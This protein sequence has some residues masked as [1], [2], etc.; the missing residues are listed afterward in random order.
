MNNSTVKE[1]VGLSKSHYTASPRG[2][3]QA[4]RKTKL[5][6]IKQRTVLN[7]KQKDRVRYQRAFRS[8]LI[9]RS[10]HLGR[11]L[12][13]EEWLAL[14]RSVRKSC[15]PDRTDPV[16]KLLKQV[17]S[18]LDAV[19]RL[20]P[21]SSSALDSSLDMMRIQ[22]SVLRQQA[23]DFM[24]EK[25][26]LTETCPHFRH[27][28]V[29]SSPSVSSVLHFEKLGM[30]HSFHY[31]ARGQVEQLC[32]PSCL[33]AR[34]DAYFS[35]YGFEPKFEHFTDVDSLLESKSQRRLLAVDPL[36]IQSIWTQLITSR[37]RSKFEP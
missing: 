32:C 26:S 8:A 20:V 25:D 13:R 34:Q 30:Q 35:W 18:R 9:A 22:L 33:S 3:G 15:Y 37:Y 10:Q 6:R 19:E 17:L 27:R 31:A 16:A 21:K 28:Q 36:S 24:Q 23:L 11:R 14:G 7:S 2:V 4:A 12:T 5:H 29:F 1:D